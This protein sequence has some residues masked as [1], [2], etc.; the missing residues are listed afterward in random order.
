[1]KL[2][3]DDY[4]KILNYYNLSIPT[5]KKALKN[6]AENILA[7]KLCKCIKK[8]SR[9]SGGRET[10][11]IGTCRKS[12]LKKKSLKAFRFKCKNKPT[13][14]TRKNKKHKL[15]KIINFKSRN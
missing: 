6:K 8:V 10:K 14:L 13:L 1:M 7:D 15:E 9:K 2:L 4:K 5:K 11:H 12:V 3:K